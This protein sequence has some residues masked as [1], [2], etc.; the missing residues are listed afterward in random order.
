MNYRDKV[1]RIFYY[2]LNLKE[3]NQK[4]IKNIYDYDK[5]YWEEDFCHTASN[6]SWVEINKDNKL[7][8]EFFSLYQESYYRILDLEKKKRKMERI[9]R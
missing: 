6:D 3:L 7:Y 9:L 8:K 4:C 2:L 5:L 1:K